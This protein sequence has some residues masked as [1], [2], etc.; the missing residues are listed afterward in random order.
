MVSLSRPER[1][2]RKKAVP[3]QDMERYARQLLL[4]EWDQ[5]ELAAS[6]VLVAG[7]G[8]LGSIVALDLVLTGVGKVII[9]D[10][11]TIE[12]SNLSRQLLFTERD[13]GKSKAV[14]AGERLRAANPDVQVLALDCPIQRVRSSIWDQVDLIVDGLDTFEARRWLNSLC[15]HKK[16]PMIHGGMY[17]WWGNV[18][19][20]IPFQTPCLECQPL[21]PAERLQKACTPPGQR[22]KEREPPPKFPSLLSVATVIAGIQFQET[23]K[24]LL[25]VGTPLDNYLFYDGLHQCFTVLKLARN[26]EC[27]VCSDRFRI[28]GEIYAVGREETVAELK[29][30]LIMTFGLENPRIV[31]RGRILRDDQVLGR[32][33]LKKREPIFILDDSLARPLKLLVILK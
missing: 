16:K 17:G 4:D 18:Q 19:R 27:F 5:E 30:R 11:D 3:Y 21:I 13:I 31:L 20:I 15:V 28:K 9:V 10:F 22:R 25:G 8:A 1:Q 23:L 33:K 6:T 29:N 12:M 14:V 2:S 26:P 7:M 24:H 32:L